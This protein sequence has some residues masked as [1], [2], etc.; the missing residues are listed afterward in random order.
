MFERV[1]SQG[2]GI[3]SNGLSRAVVN[4]RVEFFR[5]DQSPHGPNDRK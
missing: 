4:K 3:D 2:P 1:Y 5:S